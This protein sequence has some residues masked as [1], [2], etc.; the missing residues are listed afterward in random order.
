M[1]CWVGGE[2]RRIPLRV[3]L[4]ERRHEVSGEKESGSVVR[5]R[6]NRQREGLLR[7]I[8]ADRDGGG[9]VVVC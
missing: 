9:N 2:G 1:V 8:E 3:H 6:D 4:C 5:T 7:R